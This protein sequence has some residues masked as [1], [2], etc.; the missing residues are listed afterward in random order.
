MGPGAKPMI[1]RMLARTTARMRADR[2]RKRMLIRPPL[3]FEEIFEGLTHGRMDP[4][5]TGD[6]LRG[7]KDPEITIRI[8]GSTGLVSH[9]SVKLPLGD[10]P[11]PTTVTPA[12]AALAA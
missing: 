10:R 8:D 3:G 11:E 7:G 6:L 12:V 5:V 2:A 1:E 4:R 9:W